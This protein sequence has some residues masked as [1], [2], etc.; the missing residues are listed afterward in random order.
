M[1]V[2]AIISGVMSRQAPSINK[3]LQAGRIVPNVPAVAQ[4]VH[5]AQPTA[6]QPVNPTAVETVATPVAEKPTVAERP[7]EAPT[8]KEQIMA[9]AGIAQSDWD[10]TDYIISH[11]SS[12]NPTAYNTSGAYGLCQALPASKMASVGGDYMTNPVTQLKWCQ[13][14]ANDRYGSWWSA[15]AFWSAQRWW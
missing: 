6:E 1:I 12:W 11:E 10:A 3:Q 15:F 2:I 14:Y 4:E 5:A 13:Q 7:A 9:Q 8:S